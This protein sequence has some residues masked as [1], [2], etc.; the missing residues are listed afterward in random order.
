MTSFEDVRGQELSAIKTYFSQ[1]IRALEI[2]GGNGFQASLLV[3]L[4][5][6]IESIDVAKQPAGQLTFFAVEVY[7]GRTIPYSDATF[8]VVFSSNVL[9]HIRD[10]KGMM[11]EIRRVLKVD[12]VAV[13][14][15]PTP[16]WR[17]WTSLA[18]YVYLVMRVLGLQRSV[19]GGHVPSLGEKMQRS[20][21]WSTAKRILFAGPHGEYPSA[22]SE[23]W[24][25]RKARW[26][27]VFR[28]NG[29]QLMSSSPSRIFYT[30]YSVAP[31]LS[32]GVRQ[33]LAKILG[34]STYIYVLRKT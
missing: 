27:G 21:L 15:L 20:G 26:L 25:F 31:A 23:C 29:F 1:G 34:S 12:G 24:Y 6:D 4:G 14:I 19:G 17:F 9:E 11:A 10:I 7:D 5:A 32:I 13:H 18:H 8:D 3:A 30:G 16:T 2:G 33:K 22:I 28:D